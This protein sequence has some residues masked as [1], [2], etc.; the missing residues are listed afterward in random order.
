MDE[1]VPTGISNFQSTPPSVRD[2]SPDGDD[3][4]QSSDDQF[5][6]LNLA[7]PHN[8]L[9]TSRGADTFFGKSSG[10]SF[11][12]AAVEMKKELH[13]HNGSAADLI[14]EG[15]RSEGFF[16][17]RRIKFW[18][19]EQVYIYI[20]WRAQ[21]VAHPFGSGLTWDLMHRN[22]ITPFQIPTYSQAS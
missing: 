2:Y 21:T 11:I 8:R 18:Q 1:F 9:P 22:H 14:T 10:A 19:P 12:N 5:M 13:N 3:E 6:T 7:E 15:A 20:S 4:L 16:P 17:R